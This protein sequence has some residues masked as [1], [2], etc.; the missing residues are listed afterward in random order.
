VKFR[1]RL[2]NANGAPEEFWIEAGLAA[3]WTIAYRVIQPDGRPV[4]GEIRV[5]PAENPAPVPGQWS[6]LLPSVPTGGLTTRLYR[7]AQPGADFAEGLKAGN[8]Y[9]FLV[10]D[11]RPRFRAAG[12]QRLK[13]KP[14]QSGRG[15]SDQQLLDAAL[16]YVERGG[17]R[18]V[19]DLADAWK[20]KPSQARDLLQTATQKGL[21][22]AGT[23]G[24]TSRALTDK[25]KT[26]LAERTAK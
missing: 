10:P 14:R 15:W 23:R 20:L 19:A 7:A 1:H 4:I 6:G 5:F 8:R 12:F 3:E 24:R 26:L 17:R 22:T 11:A 21:L 9:L 18:P 2:G 13:K 25:A 16:L